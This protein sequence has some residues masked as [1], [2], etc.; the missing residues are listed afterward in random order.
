MKALLATILLVASAG[1]A[2]SGYLMYR[3]IFA[4]PAA[5]CTPLGEPGTILGA[6]PCAYGFVMYL[7]ITVLAAVALARRDQAE[8]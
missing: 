6:P 5:S 8:S 2:F 3:E 7:A 1:L 4:S